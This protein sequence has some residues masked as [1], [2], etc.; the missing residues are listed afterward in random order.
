MNIIVNINP[1]S[2][3]G[4]THLKTLISEPEFDISTIVSMP[5]YDMAPDTWKFYEATE[6]AIIKS[7]TEGNSTAIKTELFTCSRCK[8]KK[9]HYFEKQ[10]RSADE[11]ATLFITCDNCHKKWTQ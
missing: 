3:V 7:I 2:Y 11:P 10:V 6:N 5:A 9:C 1:E 8:Q 4:N